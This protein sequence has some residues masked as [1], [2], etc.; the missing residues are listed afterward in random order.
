[1]P[2]ILALDTATTGCSVAAVDGAS[3]IASESA[4][5]ARGQSEALAPMIERIL[6]SCPRQPAAIAVTRGPG[7]FTG[8]RIGLA[9]ARGLALAF[10]VPCLGI[11]TFDVLA[12]Q[13]RRGGQVSGL[14]ILVGID[15]KRAD[16]YAQAFND[17]GRPLTPGEAL[18]PEYL[19]RLLPDGARRLAIAGDAQE[20]VIKVFVAAR[21]DIELIRVADAEIPDAV[22]LA[23]LARP[24]LSQAAEHPPSPLYLRPPDVT[25]PKST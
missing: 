21:P 14:P 7:A 6:Q 16:L 3:V 11:S 20:A 1:M 8:L 24:L 23:E 17:Q 2:L 5:M 10:G 13:V 9:A 25:M 12:W 15:S 19:P 4:R 18:M 22:G